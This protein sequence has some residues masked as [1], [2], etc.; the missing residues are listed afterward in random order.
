VKWTVS[1]VLTGFELVKERTRLH[2]LEAADQVGYVA[3]PH[4]RNLV[5]GSSQ[6]IGLLLPNLDNGYVGTIMQGIDKALAQ[7]NYDFVLYTNHRH[8]DKESYT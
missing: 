6:I 2:V 5:G 7:A 1:R 8:P 3:N 4:A